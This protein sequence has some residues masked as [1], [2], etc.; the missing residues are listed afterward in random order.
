MPQFSTILQRFPELAEHSVAPPAL[1]PFAGI[2]DAERELSAMCAAGAPAR[3]FAMLGN[4][5][6]RRGRYLDALEAY[7]NVADLDPS[8][9]LAAWACAEIAYVLDDGATSVA[10]RTRALALQRVF[11]DPLSV[12]ERTPVLLLLRDAPYAVNAPL[13]LLLDRKRF[14]IHKYYVEGEALPALPPFALAFT[15]FGSAH[16]ASTATQRASAFVAGRGLPI[17][18]P[19]KLGGIARE[20]LASTLAGIDQVAVAGARIVDAAEVASVTLPA[21]VRPVDTH[22]GEGFALLADGGDVH[23]HLARFPA[24]QYYCSDF[25]EYRSADGLYRKFR[26]IF[27]DGVAYPYHLAIAP[28]WMVH[29][30]SAPMR[31]SSALRRE[32]L[33]FLEAPQRVLPSW[34]RVMPRIA[35]AIGLD[36]FGI[37]ASLMPDGRLLVF[38]AD[39]AMLV[40]D[41]E[42]RDVFAYK[43]PFVARIRDAL[44]TSITR[45]T[46]QRIP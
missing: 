28:S 42:A 41:E 19:A 22:A 24:A 29:Y 39:A 37:D 31:E 35:D 7:R 44:Q 36:Y 18:D 13:E 16:A 46:R 5:M 6:V 38:E 17:N 2:D 10:Y 12:A 45:R 4:V 23:R 1:L 14:A 26:A 43:R 9:A 20:T 25:V 30:Q 32:E 8:D 21:L 33:G 34:D 3:A 15:A 11:P 40:H 27:V